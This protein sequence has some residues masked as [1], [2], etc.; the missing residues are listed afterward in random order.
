MKKAILTAITLE[1]F[2]AFGKPARVPLAPITLLFGEN[3]AGKSTILQALYLLKQT[4]ELGSPDVPLLLR[5][6]NGYVDMG[7]FK[8]MVHAH[9]ANREVSIRFDVEGEPELVPVREEV[10]ECLPRQ[11]GMRFRFAEGEEHASLRL[12]GLDVFAGFHSME[13]KGSLES[14]GIHCHKAPLI[15]YAC[16]NPGDSDTRF[17]A[18]LKVAQLSRDPWYWSGALADIEEALK[19]EPVGAM[20][21]GAH[22]VYR[23]LLESTRLPIPNAAQVSQHDEDVKLLL[24][25]RYA[26]RN[27]L[28]PVDS[29]LTPAEVLSQA[30]PDEVHQAIEEA[31]QLRI[32]RDRIIRCVKEEDYGDINDFVHFIPRA[33]VA[34]RERIESEEFEQLC[35]LRGFEDCIEEEWLEAARQLGS[36]YAKTYIARLDLNSV[37][38]AVAYMVDSGLNIPIIPFEPLR[39]APRRFYQVSGLKIADVGT[40]G[41]LLGEFLAQRQDIAERV[42]TWLLRLGIDYSIEVKQIRASVSQLYE[43]RLRDTRQKRAKAVSIADVGAGIAQILPFLAQTLAEHGALITIEQPELHIHPRL[44]SELG[45]LFV[46]GIAKGNRFIIETHS[47]HLILRLQKL[48]RTGKLRPEDVAVLYV[49]RGPE[50]STVEQLRL[51]EE[52]DFIDDWPGG[53]FPERLKELEDE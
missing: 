24:L 45:S 5:A 28:D 2:K 38:Y 53:F 23:D 7:S 15:Y 10:G 14:V 33:A 41:E 51:D 1:N 9:D 3:S 11:V 20:Q 13:G 21:E 43:I 42:N 48:I 4:R 17:R 31:W 25:D 40:T 27:V 22:R 50:G 34:T 49:A 39:A 16:K 52:G 37:T 44:Q 30:T 47:E 35:F 12:S 18:G 8:E 6:E 29:W 26:S 46:D 32:V 36:I 19:S